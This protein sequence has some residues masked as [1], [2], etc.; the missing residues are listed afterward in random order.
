MI[1]CLRVTRLRDNGLGQ[2]VARNRQLIATSAETASVRRG[3]TRQ[4]D[5]IAL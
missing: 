3:L 1:Q 2:R 5:S 4:R